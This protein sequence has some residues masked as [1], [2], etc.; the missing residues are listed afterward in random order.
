VPLVGSES[1][2]AAQQRGFAA[3][4]GAHDD[5]EIAFV[6]FQI[7]AIEYALAG[8]FLDQIVNGDQWHEIVPDMHG[9]CYE[10]S[11]SGAQ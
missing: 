10:A 4:G 6:N 9:V 8:K 3:A 1:V 11:M 2:Q 7:D 5:F